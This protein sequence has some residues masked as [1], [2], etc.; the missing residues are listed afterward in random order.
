M[1]DTLYEGAAH[2]RLLR[3]LLTLALFAGLGLAAAAGAPRSASAQTLNAGSPDLV[4]TQVY[5]R[6]GEPGATYRN[7]YIELFNR[8][9]T[10]INLADYSVQALVVAQPQPGFP[11]GLVTVITR[12]VSSGGG[13]ALEPGRY[14]LLAYG[15]SGNNGAPVPDAFFTSADFNM[16]S[17][18]GRVALVRGV[19]PLAQ[20]GCA[21][22]ADAALVDFF[23]YGTATC[24]EYRQ[25]FAQ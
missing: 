9:N 7:D 17:N 4:I 6:G 13:V 24:A 5:T 3:R 16:P 21:P 11:G 8:G 18:F 19:A 23:S 14:K 15:S 25:R 2:T 1:S 22:G 10:S 20:Y 12:F